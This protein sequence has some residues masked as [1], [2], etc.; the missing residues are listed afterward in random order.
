[1]DSFSNKKQW[2]SL[3]QWQQLHRVLSR[4]EKIALPILV[5]VFVVSLFSF[6]NGFY[7]QN[8]TV[9]PAKGGNLT[10]GVV[11]SVRFLNPLYADTNDADRDLVQLIYSGILTYNSQGELVPDLASEMPEIS[12]GGRVITVRLKENVQ[13]HDGTPFSAD[14]V[15]FTI[16]AL[17]DP[18]SKSPIRAN[19]IGVDAEKVSD[20]VVRF[21]LLDSYAP[22]LERLTIQILPAHLWSEISPENYSLTPLNLQPVGTGP[23][24]L[25]NISQG[26]SGVVE[27]VRLEAYENYHEEG[28]FIEHF[29]F[30]FFAN[31]QDLITEASR[32]G[33]Q[34]FSLNKISNA[35][36][37]KNPSFASYPFSL[38]RYFALFFNMQAPTDQEQLEARNV[39]EALY[40]ALD[41]QALISNVFQE[42]ATIID[43]PFLPDI[44]GFAKP[45]TPNTPD[46]ER[47]L[48]LLEQEGYIKEQGA[49]G[50]AQLTSE[51]LQQDLIRGDSG[52]EVR[53][54]QQ[55]LA[56][57]SEVYPE[58]IVNGSFGQLTHEAV[59]RF[60]EKYASEVLAPLGLS[61]GTGKA[62]ELTRE[63]LNALCFSGA[64]Q[65]TPLL[66]TIATVDQSPLQDVAQEIKRQWEEFGLQVEV[67]TF[68]SSVLERDILKPRAYQTLL[69]GEV[70]GKI[71]DPFPFWHSS[72][73]QTPG[74]NL[75]AYEN[76]ALDTQLE[77][78]RKETDTQ[79]RANQLENMQELLL[80]DLPLIPL[81]DV[82]HYYFA[83]K[84]VKGIETSVIADP[85]QRFSGVTEWYIHTKRVRD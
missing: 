42:D 78:L 49:I 65:S 29:T 40:L 77:S 67:Q 71:P 4:R 76:Q 81:Y 2:P 74:L 28:P 43:S 34:S 33:I 50:K 59:I 48:S 11:G 53:K 21:H 22:F 3:S 44:Y 15:I 14:D 79:A 68:S 38:P 27:E 5:L 7:Y 9:T 58:G 37:M 56:R 8:A 72:Q 85:S 66:V 45:N 57:D 12:E 20:H 82:P 32:G 52:A 39:R 73:I 47:A 36:Q 17:Q 46:R 30:R 18:D 35:Q 62:G 24:T 41:K 61:E 16:A 80:E 54:L 26:R 25:E 63:K 51:A 70:L 13:W 31:E 19:W 84:E 69:F 60:Q 55:C 83:A 75:S 64:G 6:A 23:Y 1:M 10:E